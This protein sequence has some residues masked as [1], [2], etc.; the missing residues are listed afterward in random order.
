MLFLLGLVLLL[1]DL[2]AAEWRDWR[3]LEDGWGDWR[4]DVG[5]EGDEGVDGRGECG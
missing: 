5:D 4:M 2:V 3:G 1:G